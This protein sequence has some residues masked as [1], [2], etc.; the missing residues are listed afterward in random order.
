MEAAEE[1]IE[2][3]VVESSWQ[4]VGAFRK[5]YPTRSVG[6]ASVIETTTRRPPPATAR[7]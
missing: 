3:I 6:A 2:A 5:A 4:S 1:I 7:A